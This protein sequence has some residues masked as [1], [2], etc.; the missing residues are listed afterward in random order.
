[1]KESFIGQFLKQMK[2]KALALAKYVDAE[3]LVLLASLVSA[4]TACEIVNFL[5]QQVKY[6]RTGS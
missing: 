4:C 1:M 5:Q 2:L 6:S 3:P